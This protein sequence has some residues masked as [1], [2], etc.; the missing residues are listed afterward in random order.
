[1]AHQDSTPSVEAI[2]FV[3]G[4]EGGYYDGSDPRDPNPTNYGVTQRTYDDYRKRH[5]L[6]TRPVREITMPE[7]QDIYASYWVPGLPRLTGIAVF[8]HSINAG[9]GNARRALQRAAGVTDDGIIGPKTRAAIAAVPDDVLAD[10]VCWE[11]LR[12]YLDIAERSRRLRPNLTSWLLRVVK[13][14]ERFLS[15]TEYHK[16]A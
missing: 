16:A 9:P 3:L 14:R 2:S 5:G 6:A 13:F 15:G 4:N 8:D 11:R 12:Y 7:V 10:R 1:M